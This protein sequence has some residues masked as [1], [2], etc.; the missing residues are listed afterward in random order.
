MNDNKVNKIRISSK[1]N[2]TRTKFY[3]RLD[4]QL[5]EYVSDDIVYSYSYWN[6]EDTCHSVKNDI[7]GSVIKKGYKI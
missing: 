5:R 4:K 3:N 6:G 7:M 1:F 2:T